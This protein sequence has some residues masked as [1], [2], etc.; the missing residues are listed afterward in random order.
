VF[1]GNHSILKGKALLEMENDQGIPP[2]RIAF[3]FAVSA[4]HHGSSCTHKVFGRAGVVTAF[5]LARV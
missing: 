2:R 5:M 1:I 3:T 4:G